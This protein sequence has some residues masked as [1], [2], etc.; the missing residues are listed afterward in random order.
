MREFRDLA[1]RVVFA[2]PV[3]DMKPGREDKAPSFA[4]ELNA[5]GKSVFLYLL[6]AQEGSTVSDL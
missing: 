2:R 3:S 4:A 5:T 1:A 6:F